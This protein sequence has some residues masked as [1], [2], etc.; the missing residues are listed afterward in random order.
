MQATQGYCHTLFMKTWENIHFAGDLFVCFL[1]W[2][3]TQFEKHKIIIERETAE[4]G[5]T[6]AEVAFNVW[7]RVG[8][9]APCAWCECASEQ[10]SQQVNESEFS[11]FWCSKHRTKRG[12]ARRAIM[13]DGDTGEGMDG[14]T[15]QI[16]QRYLESNKQ[17]GEGNSICV[18]FSW[19]MHFIVGTGHEE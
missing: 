8:V 4:H 17:K 19:C 2:N 14:L 5:I 13:V 6:W 15:R 16:Q 12:H 3:N 18:A 1:H 7:L 10:A 9:F 11:L